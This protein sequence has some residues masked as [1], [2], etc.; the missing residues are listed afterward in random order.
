MLTTERAK[1]HTNGNR[2][3]KTRNLQETILFA[4]CC[5]SIV[6]TCVLSWN[7]TGIMHPNNLQ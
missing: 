1:K 6:L 5:F 7:D 4:C 2:Q 3:Q